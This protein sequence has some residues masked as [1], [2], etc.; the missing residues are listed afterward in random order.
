[1]ALTDNILTSDV[2]N[3]TDENNFF[4]LRFLVTRSNND[5]GEPDEVEAECIISPGVNCKDFKLFITK[6]CYVSPEQSTEEIQNITHRRYGRLLKQNNAEI[7]IT[8]GGNSKR[9]KVDI[10][11]RKK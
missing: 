6:G 8:Y 11:T 7:T 1:M 4:I 2:R 3:M 5:D 9:I 10:E